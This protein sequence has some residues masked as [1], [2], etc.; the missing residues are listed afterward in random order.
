MSTSVMRNAPLFKPFKLALIQLG[1]I[2]ANKTENLQH[3]RA[4]VL[5]AAAGKPDLIV[6][7]VRV[8]VVQAR[9]IFKCKHL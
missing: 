3:A 5:E 9:T 2:G 6:L 1:G 8:S 4:K 7:P